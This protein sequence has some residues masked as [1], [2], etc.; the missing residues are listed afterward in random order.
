[1]VVFLFKLVGKCGRNGRIQK[2]KLFYVKVLKSKCL[3]KR[4]V[5]SFVPSF[6]EIT[7]VKF[8]CITYMKELVGRHC[9]IK[10]KI[11]GLVITMI[12]RFSCE[13]PEVQKPGLVRDL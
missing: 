4:L 2:K 12:C 3:I 6:L 1:M 11:S 10:V 5:S 8:E 13:M 7:R 9:F